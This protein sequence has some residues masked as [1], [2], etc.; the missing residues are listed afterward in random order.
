MSFFYPVPWK[1]D[2]QWPYCLL[3]SSSAGGDKLHCTYSSLFSSCSSVGTPQLVPSGRLWLSWKHV[4]DFISCVLQQQPW[5]TIE[6]GRSTVWFVN[7]QER[8]RV[9]E[10]PHCFSQALSRQA[11]SHPY[12]VFPSRGSPAGPCP[13]WTPDAS[14]K[15]LEIHR[16]VSSCYQSRPQGSVWKHFPGPAFRAVGQHV[17]WVNTCK[18][19]TPPSKL[20]IPMCL[21]NFTSGLS[22]SAGASRW[23]LPLGARIWGGVVESVTGRGI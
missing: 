12:F 1:R 8:F 20:C 2:G 22:S 3:P 21:L 23:M 5:R 17:P 14:T 6:G 15:L 19:L 10:V 13:A 16:W 9:R 4:G 7:M 11:R 18:L